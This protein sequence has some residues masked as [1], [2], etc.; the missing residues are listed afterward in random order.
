MLRVFV[1]LIEVAA[2]ID[3]R[4]RSFSTFAYFG[5]LENFGT[6]SYSTVSFSPLIVVGH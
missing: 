3:S 1:Q 6:E 2:S 5:S 4:L